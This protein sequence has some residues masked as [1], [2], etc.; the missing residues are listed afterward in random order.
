MV[1]R[2][3]EDGSRI[4][5]V[6]QPSGTREVILLLDGAKVSRVV[7]IPMLM[8]IGAAVVRMDGVGGVETS[9]ELRHRGYSRRVMEAVVEQIK[10]GDASI[11]TLFGIQDFYQKFGYETAGPELTTILP[12]SDH[13]QFA[14]DLPS[15]WR[16]RPLAEGDLPALMA[17]Y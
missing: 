9:E 8:R 7:V 12:N 11:S 14:P 1:E 3:F 6:K 17:L 5:T 16:F 13:P 15:G 10:A 4:T 2:D